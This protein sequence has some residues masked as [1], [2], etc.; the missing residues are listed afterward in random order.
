MSKMKESRLIITAEYPI[1]LVIVVI[2]CCLEEVIRLLPLRVLG[3]GELCALSLL[4]LRLIYRGA[5]QCL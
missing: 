1:W 5:P 3:S 2:G 4:V